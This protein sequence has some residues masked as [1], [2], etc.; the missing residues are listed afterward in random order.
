MKI[1][2]PGNYFARLFFHNFPKEI[3]ESIQFFPSS[4]IAAELNK[5][6]DSV[7]LLPAMDLIKNK[8]LYVSKSAGISFEGDLSNSFIYYPGSDRNASELTL[9]GD[10]SSCEVILSKI[11]F[12]ELYNLDVSIALSIASGL[13]DTK[14]SI[15]SGDKNFEGDLFAKGF[16]MAEE[17]VELIN[18][19]FVNYV[20][21]SGNSGL[22]EQFNSIAAEAITRF[23]EN[24][25]EAISQLIPENLQE[26]F[27]ANIPTLIFNFEEQDLEGMIQLLQLPYFHG[28]INDI[29]EL[30][31]V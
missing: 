27:T 12:K 1:I 9:A 19:P 24:P 2:T 26:F 20:C 29:I 10:I 28:M 21:A 31:L 15:L 11:L 6:K 22:L 23:Y 14:T 5:D 13:D 7:A 18:L 3:K 30:N 25:A 17:V 16:G 4:L 8:D